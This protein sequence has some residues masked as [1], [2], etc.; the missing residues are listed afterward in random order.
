MYRKTVLLTSNRSIYYCT[1]DIK[2]VLVSRDGR[3]KV[4]GL[5]II[6]SKRVFFLS[7]IHIIVSPSLIQ[8]TITR[9][10]DQQRHNLSKSLQLYMAENGPSYPWII[11]IYYYYSSE[12]LI[13]CS[14][15]LM[16]GRDMKLEE[17]KK[18]IL[19]L[20]S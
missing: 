10:I 5:Y 9:C 14:Y 15:I 12:N 16:T 4:I 11:G 17:K 2:S 19:F 8:D 1:R 7:F 20:V 18:M 13:R 6:T 3:S